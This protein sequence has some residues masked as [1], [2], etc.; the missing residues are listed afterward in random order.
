V[1]VLGL[2]LQGVAEAVCQLE[3]Q[4]GGQAGV[5]DVQTDEAAG[6]I[7]LGHQVDRVT[8]TTADVD[9]VDALLQPIDDAGHNRQDGVD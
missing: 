1:L 5:S 9:H 4:L 6:G 7:R 8:R 2:G 3:A